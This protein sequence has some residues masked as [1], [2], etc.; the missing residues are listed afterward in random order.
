M[1]RVLSVDSQGRL[2]LEQRRPPATDDPLQ[3]SETVLDV[4]RIVFARR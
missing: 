2:V 1:E 4:R 3:A